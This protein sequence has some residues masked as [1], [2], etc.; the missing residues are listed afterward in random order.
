M[1]HRILFPTL[2]FLVD[3]LSWMPGQV[4]WLLW[5]PFP[6]VLG[7]HVASSSWKILCTRWSCNF[8]F[9]A[10]NAPTPSQSSSSSTSSPPLRIKNSSTGVSG[11]SALLSADCQSETPNRNL[12]TSSYSQALSGLSFFETPCQRNPVWIQIQMDLQESHG[13]GGTVRRARR[14]REVVEKRG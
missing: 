6:E 14:K 9:K 10:S 1:M 3:K 4:G 5:I 8:P 12:R 13:M 11:T 2:T 7:R